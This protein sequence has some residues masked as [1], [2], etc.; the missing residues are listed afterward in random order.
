M[1]LGFI[2]GSEP[3]TS[4]DLSVAAP[5]WPLPTGKVSETV[6]V[7]GPQGCHSA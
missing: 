7:I 5:I 2:G 4:A 3:E 6:L 1:P